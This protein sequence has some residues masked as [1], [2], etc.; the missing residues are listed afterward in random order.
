MQAKRLSWLVILFLL[1][2][3]ALPLLSMFVQSVFKNGTLSFSLLFTTFQNTHLL[4]SLFH[5]LLLGFIVAFFTAF[6]GTFMGLVLGKTDMS[7]RSVFVVIFITPLLI[8]PYIL[9]FSWYALLG[10]HTFLGELLFS[11]WGVSFVLFSVYLPIPMLLTLL[12]TKQINPHL[13]ESA[14]LLYSW[15]KVLLKITLPLLFPS[16]L[17]SAILVF[18][19]TISE[20][21]VA[22]FFRFDVFALQSFTAFS[23]FYDFKSATI[24]K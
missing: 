23:A 16:V 1:L 11:F 9:A 17:F 2:V 18:I 24:F 12:F 13:E 15:R 10:R 21:S 3:G 4:F 14:L 6:V 5:T 8:A 7:Y 19:L 22:N 20:I